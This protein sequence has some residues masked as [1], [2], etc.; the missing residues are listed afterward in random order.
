LIGSPDVAKELGSEAHRRVTANHLDDR[1]VIRT[2]ELLE[3]M[4]SS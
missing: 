2:T 4:L 1:H 3:G